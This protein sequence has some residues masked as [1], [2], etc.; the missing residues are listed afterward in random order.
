M[1]HPIASAPHS[2]PSASLGNVIGWT[3]VQIE[4]VASIR[5][6]GSLCGALAMAW[7]TLPID[8][9]SMSRKAEERPSNTQKAARKKKKRSNKITYRGTRV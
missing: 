6:D 1:L 5:V 9:G 3:S 2:E 4:I 7:S 8:P